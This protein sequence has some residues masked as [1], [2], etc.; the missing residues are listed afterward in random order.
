MKMITA[1]SL[2][3]AAALLTACG[4]ELFNDSM[5]P[6]TYSHP[7]NHETRLHR[8]TAEAW[9]TDT[10]NTQKNPSVAENAPAA[11]SR[12]EEAT[13]RQVVKPATVRTKASVPTDGPFVPQMAP[14]VGR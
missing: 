14:T 13:E 6:A 10:M 7:E 4:D 12:T 3:L 9:S 11:R 2:S 1:V 8:V 5:P